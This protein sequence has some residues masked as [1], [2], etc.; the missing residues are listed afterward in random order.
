MRFYPVQPHVVVLATLL[1]LYLLIPGLIAVA[2]DACT[3]PPPL[4]KMDTWPQNATVRFW[5]DPNFL[6]V[7]K[8]AIRQ[9]FGDW[10][11]ANTPTG[12][13]SSTT[14]ALNP[15]VGAWAVVF[16]NGLGDGFTKTIAGFVVPVRGGL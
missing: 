12:N 6:E 5:I 11:V 16:F 13:W 9:T 15:A 14:V 1:G 2:Q 7:Q 3:D 10:N 4:T 8:Q